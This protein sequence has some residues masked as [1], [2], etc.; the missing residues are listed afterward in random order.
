MF[1]VNFRRCLLFSILFYVTLFIGPALGADCVEITAPKN[2]AKVQDSVLFEG[3]AQLPAGHHMWL[4]IGIAGTK[5]WWPQGG[6]EA[7]L[8]GDS[9]EVLARV[10]REGGDWGMKFR[11]AAVVVT[12]RVHDQLQKWV[13]SSATAK[14]WDPISMPDVSEACKVEV[15]RFEKSR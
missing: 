6:G 3:T 5:D 9:W 13:T 11:A 1:L 14:R 10:G 7:E 8:I 2:G 15:I 12:P 4:L